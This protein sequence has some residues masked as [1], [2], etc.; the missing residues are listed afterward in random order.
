MIQYDKTFESK[1]V[2]PMETID[3]NEEKSRADLELHDA[4]IEGIQKDYQTLLLVNKELNNKSN[5]L[6]KGYLK[7]ILSLEDKILQ[8][9]R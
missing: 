3:A 1:F 8:L 2:K 4:L 5:I 9:Y 6:K 7:Y